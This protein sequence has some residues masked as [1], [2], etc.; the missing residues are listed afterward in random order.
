MNVTPLELEG[1]LL[2]EP[3]VHRD[4]RGALLEL[5][6]KHRYDG[7]VAGDDFVQDNL[8][9]TAKG[10]LRGLHYQHPAGQGKLVTVVAGAAFDVVLDVRRGS[11]SFGKWLSIELA[12]ANRRQLWIPPGFAHGFQALQDDT[13]LIYKVTQKWE[14]E[15]ERTVLYSDPD[16]AIAWPLPVT[17]ASA[18]DT[19]AARL[20]HMYP[21]HLPER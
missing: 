13:T 1:V 8:T 5:W 18:R 19:A 11:P 16:L 17:V 15:Y 14:P 3:A 12:A 10:A 9:V 2:I 20:A 21:A 7:H 6:A 4:D